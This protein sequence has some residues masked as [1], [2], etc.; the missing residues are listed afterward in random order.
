MAAKPTPGGSD[1]TY[2]T[3]LNEFLD[4]SLASD[5]KVKDG[6]VLEAATE[7]ADGDRTIADAAFV[8]A[9]GFP[10]I[11]GT[12][13]AVTTIYLTGSLDADDSTDVAH[14]IDVG[15]GSV[16]LHVSAMV[17][18]GTAD[19]WVSDINV[20]STTAVDSQRF[21]LN[22]GATAVKFRHVGSTFQSQSFVV[23]IDFK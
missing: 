12:P 8:K 13:T 22:V 17:N 10:G 11:D 23:K 14:G 21:E 6:A 15:G 18:D 16:I 20:D 4:V 3:E 9:N 1:G 19:W 5:G 2:G 7:P